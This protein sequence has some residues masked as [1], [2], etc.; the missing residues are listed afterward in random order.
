MKWSVT[1]IAATF[2]TINRLHLSV[3]NMCRLFTYI[4][5]SEPQLLADVL[6]APAHSLSKQVHDRYLPYLTHY[7]P[8]DNATDT[9]KEISTRNS[10]YNMDGLG[11]AWYANP[12]SQN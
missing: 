7:E 4:S 11:I 9:K 12:A 6:I 2:H 1:A 8:D 3:C 10:P 5:D